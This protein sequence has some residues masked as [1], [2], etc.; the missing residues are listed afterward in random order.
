MAFRIA[1]RPEMT[2]S[3]RTSPVKAK[4]YLGWLHQLPCIV[5]RS[6]PVEAAHVSYA[7]PAFG[8]TGRGKGQK[9]SDRWALPLSPEEHRKQHG[10]NEQEY[11]RSVGINP[12]LAACILYGL[13]EER[14]DEAT[15]MATRLILSGIGRYE[16]NEG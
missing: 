7:N 14:G 4:S 5:T 2:V 6:Q 13:F 1:P 11:W 9:A 16:R 15:E 10:M 12:H 3:R 8:A